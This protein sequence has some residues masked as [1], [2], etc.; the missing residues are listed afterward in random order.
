MTNIRSKLKFNESYCYTSW[1]EELRDKLVIVGYSKDHVRH[2]LEKWLMGAT[3]FY[4][5]Y[6]CDSGE[7]DKPFC[8]M[9]DDTL[10]E[11]VYYD[12]ELSDFLQR[13]R[14]DRLERS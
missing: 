10:W 6:V 12:P 5:D 4:V 1:S 2:T 7:E 9:E 14:D 3:L 11:V 13:R 8:D